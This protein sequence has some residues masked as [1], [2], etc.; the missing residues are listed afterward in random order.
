MSG[1]APLSGE[2]VQQL[3]KI[4]PNASIG[5]GYGMKVLPSCFFSSNLQRDAGLT[6]TC[7]TVAMFHPTQKI[8]TLGSAGML[9]PGTRARVVKADGTLAGEG[10]RGELGVYES[11]ALRGGVGRSA[12]LSRRR[13]RMLDV[14]SSS[15]F[16]GLTGRCFGREGW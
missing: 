11:G 7:T 12:S 10:E 3:V 13:I 16:F 4:F 14:R 6:E 2:M 5:Q 15:I 8:G 1:A 9:I